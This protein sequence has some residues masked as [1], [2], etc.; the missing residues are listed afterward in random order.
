M[1]K[2]EKI[3]AAAI[4]VFQEKGIEKT[5]VSD[6][7]KM[8]GIAQGTFYLYF[9]SKLSV[10]PEIAEV[11]VKKVLVAME[12]RVEKNTSLVRT[13]TQTIE[14][15][16][17]FTKEHREI[18]AL[19]YAGLTQT[20]H[21]MEWEAIYEPFYEWMRALLVEAKNAGEIRADVEVD[22]VAKVLIGA[23]ESTAEQAYLYATPPA[24]TEALKQQ[25]I[26]LEFLC[27]GLGCSSFAS[28]N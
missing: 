5:K 13:L 16:W 18:L 28:Q 20:K 23:I 21:M 26:V 22:Y 6:I 8:A 14:T 11:M 10:M 15:V 7:V 27:R 25:K 17:L 1:D 2:K 3:I 19:V 24:Q 4:G 9:P 12:E